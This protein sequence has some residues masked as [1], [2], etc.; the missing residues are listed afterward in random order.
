MKENEHLEAGGP[1]LLSVVLQEVEQ[2][3][4]L[5]AGHLEHFRC[6]V[7]DVALVQ[8]PEKCPAYSH[9]PCQSW[10]MT[11]ISDVPP[12]LIHRSSAR[13]LHFLG[14]LLGALLRVA[15]FQ[16]FLMLHTLRGCRFRGKPRLKNVTMTAA[17]SL[18]DAGG[19]GAL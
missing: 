14:A 6:S 15:P 13:N 18:E 17:Q 5:D 3:R 8:R 11:S 12:P 10:Q 4:I 19:I 7:A 9:R 2:L 1:E 16:P